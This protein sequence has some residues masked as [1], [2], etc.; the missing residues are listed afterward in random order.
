MA[1]PPAPRRGGE[2]LYCFSTQRTPGSCRR[3]P[4]VHAECATATGRRQCRPPTG[5]CGRCRRCARVTPTRCPPP[6]PARGSRGTRG[7][8]RRLPGALTGVRDGQQPSDCGCCVL[9]ATLQSGSPDASAARK[10]VSLLSRWRVRSRSS[11]FTVCSSSTSCS[12]CSMFMSTPPTCG[13]APG[14]V[15]QAP[16]RFTLSDVGQVRRRAGAASVQDPA[17]CWPTPGPH[18]TNIRPETVTDEQSPDAPKTAGQT[19]RRQTTA[20]VDKCVV[21]FR[22]K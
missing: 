20:D 19:M 8:R 4:R 1:E 17:H 11:A 2:G 21:D 12:C 5:R 10:A 13:P 3:R 14:L 9:A 6:P 7:A 18:D 15:A 22:Y 16:G